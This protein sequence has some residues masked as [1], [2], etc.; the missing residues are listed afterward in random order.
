MN[1]SKIEST[2]QLVFEDKEIL[3]IIFARSISH[4][5][6]SFQFKKIVCNSEL[7]YQ[8]DNFNTSLSELRESKNS[9]LRIIGENGDIQIR[10]NFSFLTVKFQYNNKTNDITNVFNA[11]CNIKE[12]V[13]A[14][15][16]NRYD[17]LWQSN[18]S[19]DFAK[20]NGQILESTKIYVD[21]L[22]RKL[23]DV[24]ENYGRKVTIFPGFE[25]V[26]ASEY[27]LNEDYKEDINV[28]N[29]LLSFN[30]YKNR[31]V[32]TEGVVY[33]KLYE[34]DESYR[35]IQEKLWKHIDIDDFLHQLVRGM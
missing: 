31:S 20:L 8:S 15:H 14:I 1:V 4:F 22:G 19:Y 2:L 17:V 26:I 5:E 12:F 25:F 6:L 24:A 27:W 21:K 34:F 28:I 10:R 11:I 33:L 23:I 3:P 16:Y 18:K 9:I 13:F 35:K 7:E 32:F 30:G 29:K